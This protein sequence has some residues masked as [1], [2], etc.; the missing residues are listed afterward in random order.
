MLVIGGGAMLPGFCGRLAEELRRAA[1]TQPRFRELAAALEPSS[2]SS[3]SGGLCVVRDA[4]V[5]APRN[6]L[7]WTGGSVLAVL[8]EAGAGG[9]AGG[10]RGVGVGRGGR[11]GDG[12]G[13]GSR[14]VWRS[15]WVEAEALGGA[16]RL[17]PEWCMVGGGMDEDGGEPN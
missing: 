15:D 9:G 7:A 10:G 12:G 1:A 5:L 14:Y 8:E 16:G 2:N 11:G 13:R 3:G 6:V 4:C 17:L